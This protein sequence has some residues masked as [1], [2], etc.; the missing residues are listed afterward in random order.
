[1]EHLRRLDD[2]RNLGQKLALVVF[3]LNPAL[4]WLDR[5]LGMER[6][7]ACDESVLEATRAPKAYASCLVHLAE[8]SA[9]GRHLSLALGAWERRSELARRV[10]GILGYRFGEGT[11]QGRN[12]MGAVALVSASLVLGATL[13]HAPQLITFAAPAPV[14]S[15][16]APGVF[17]LPLRADYTPVALRPAGGGSPHVVEAVAHMPAHA[18]P[19]RQRQP[20]SGLKRTTRNLRLRRAAASRGTVRGFALTSWSVAFVAF[21]RDPHDEN[22]PARPQ[23]TFTVFDPSTRSLRPLTAP[24]AFIPV[25]IP[26]GMTSSFIVFQL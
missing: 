12:R 1:M 16:S 22:A 26:T 2:W 11:G 20:G 18:R 9:I 3:P 5:R 8:E 25:A 6:E 19:V 23:L 21:D 7:L 14:T 24:Q 10:H 15:A 13:A 17:T 4:L